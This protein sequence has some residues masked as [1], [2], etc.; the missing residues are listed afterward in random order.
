GRSW[1]WAYGWAA[2]RRLVRPM[3]PSTATSTIPTTT[4]RT[5]TGPARGPSGRKS[6][7][8]LICGRRLTWPTRLLGKTTG[9]I[10]YGRRNC[11]TTATT[12]GSTSFEVAPYEHRDSWVVFTPAI[13][14]G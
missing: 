4:F 13:G 5:T 6:R 12:S 3:N 11:I 1:A 10:T 9:A 14:P 2:A 8:T 7:A